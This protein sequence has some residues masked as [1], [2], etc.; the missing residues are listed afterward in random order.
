VSDVNTR[1]DVPHSRFNEIGRDQFERA[2][3]PILVESESAGVHLAVS[4]DGFRIVFFQGHPEYD[5]VSLLKEYKREVVRFA[6]R[7]RP[8]YPP[9]IQNY[10]NAQAR[11]ILEEHKGRVVAAVNAG[12]PAPELPETL[13]AA[14]LDNTWH[15]TAEAVINNWIGRVYQITNIDRKLPFAQGVDPNDPL[16]LRTSKG[17]P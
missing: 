7:E 12:K 3:L 6:I 13:I 2:K 10:C 17:S 14:S 5:T 1:F 8:D 11:A 4:E 15:D 16:G 9:L